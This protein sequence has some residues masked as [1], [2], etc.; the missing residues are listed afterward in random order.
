[1]SSIGGGITVLGIDP[2]TGR[3]GYGIIRF[4]AG[5]MEVL[6][7][8][9]F[10]YPKAMPLHERFVRLEQDLE[11]L[12]ETYKPEVMAVETLIF[13][14]NVT[15]AM[16]VSEARGIIVLTGARRKI[17]IQACTP[18]Q[19]KVAVTGYGR[20]DKSQ[21]AHMIML[22]LKLTEKRI[23]DDTLDALAIAITGYS[24][25]TTQQFQKG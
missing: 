1:M 11:Q 18:M 10:E 6:G 14:R 2:G 19:V 8:G 16:Q 21:V 4:K 25:Y 15:T 17:P 12:H 3:C 20:A 22:Q 9:T 7:Y 13:N 24:L 5:G 23:L